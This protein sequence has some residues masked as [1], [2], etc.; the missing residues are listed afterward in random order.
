MSPVGT[1]DR[2][3]GNLCS[4]EELRPLHL[5]LLREWNELDDE[6]KAKKAEQF[7]RTAAKTGAWI[8]SLEERDAV[9]GMIDYWTATVATIPDVEFPD[10]VLIAEFK[11]STVQKT[12][13]NC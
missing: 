3:P 7:R 4:A 8:K 13:R 10:P 9:Q 12:K 5:A 1:L 2:P 6:A 11:P